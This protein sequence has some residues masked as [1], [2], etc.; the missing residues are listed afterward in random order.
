MRA[1]GVV[2]ER[3]NL[4]RVALKRPG[5]SRTRLDD[6]AVRRRSTVVAGRRGGRAA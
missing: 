1:E 6:D 4:P 3:K 2:G 5:G